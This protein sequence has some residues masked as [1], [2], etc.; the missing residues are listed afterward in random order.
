QAAGMS[1]LSLLCLF[2]SVTVVASSDILPEGYYGR[3]KLDHSENFDDYLSAKGYGWLTR[4]LVSL[5][6]VTKVFKK[7]GPTSFDYENLTTKKDIHYKG[8]VLGKEF[9]GEGLDSSKQKVTFSLRGGRLYEKHVPTDAD[10]E[11]KED[12]YAYK[13]NG[14]TLVQTLQASGVVAKRYFQRQ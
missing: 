13:L 14:D 9:I 1:R 3:F 4:R 12:E 5:A 8:V 2:I 6:S 7:A 10:A 11:Q